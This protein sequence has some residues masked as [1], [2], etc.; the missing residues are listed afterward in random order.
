MKKR[1]GATLAEGYLWKYPLRPWGARVYAVGARW[2]KGGDI[3]DQERYKLSD[4]RPR[5]EE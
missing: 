4:Y 3:V 1:L 5:V 2:L